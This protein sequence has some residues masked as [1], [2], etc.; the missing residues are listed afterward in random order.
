M[1]SVS[2]AV[3]AALATEEKKTLQ[4]KNSSK[5]LPHIFNIPLLYPIKSKN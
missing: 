3:E 2:A 1:S 5:Q 4:V